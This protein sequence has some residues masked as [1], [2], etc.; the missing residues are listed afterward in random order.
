M[1]ILK[2]GQVT[3]KNISLLCFFLLA[4]TPALADHH[5]VEISQIVKLDDDHCAVELNIAASNQD[6]FAD[7][8]ELQLGGDAI[9]D[10]SS[11]VSAGING[12]GGNNDTGDKILLASESF[13]DAFELDADIT[14]DDAACLDLE[15]QTSLALVIDDDASGTAE[16]TVDEIDPSDQVGF[17]DNTAIVRQSDDSF[18]VIDLDDDAITLTNNDEDAQEFNGDEIADSGNSSTAVTSTNTCAFH[19]LT[20]ASTAN[21]SFSQCLILLVEMA[22]IVATRLST[23]PLSDS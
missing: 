16:T 12:S 20:S 19:P 7:A 9:A 4:A 14:F 8:D 17:D 18:D 13:D 1:I 21:I 3:M 2:R 22:I 5:L 6:G 23:L 10:F 15:D 11:L